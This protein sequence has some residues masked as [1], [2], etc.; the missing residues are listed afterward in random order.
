MLQMLL[1]YKY[2]KINPRA[3]NQLS[4]Q[5]NYF[6]DFNLYLKLYMGLFW[7]SPLKF[8]MFYTKLYYIVYMLHN[9]Y[10]IFNIL[11]KIHK[12]S[13]IQVLFIYIHIYIHM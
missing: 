11:Y 13:L 6:L 5:K 3:C 9:R 12:Q 7:C 2:P 1:V 8:G 10:F 4:I